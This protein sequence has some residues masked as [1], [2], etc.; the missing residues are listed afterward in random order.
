MIRYKIDQSV[1][2]KNFSCEEKKSTEEYGTKFSNESTIKLEIK[3]YEYFSS[4][5]LFWNIQSWIF[6]S[7]SYVIATASAA[8]KT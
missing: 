3:D 4:P 2:L 1:D 5:I 6:N 7:F 8:N